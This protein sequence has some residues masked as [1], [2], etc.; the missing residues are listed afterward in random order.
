MQY[1]KLEHECMFVCPVRYIIGYTLILQIYYQSGFDTIIENIDTLDNTTSFT[2]TGLMPS[3]SYT[4]YLSAFTGAGEG[5][6]SVN[7]TS[8]T[9]FEGKC[10][11][12][13]RVE[14]GSH[15]LTHLTH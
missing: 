4:V 3:T 12:T 8:T 7:I 6:F 9:T 2:V 13:A 11:I 5:D 14:S 1:G 10:I 15:L